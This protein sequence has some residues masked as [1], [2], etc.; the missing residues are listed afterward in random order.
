MITQQ[1][2]IL[3]QE[4]TMLQHHTSIMNKL[5]KIIFRHHIASVCLP[6]SKILHKN[7]VVVALRNKASKCSHDGPS[8]SLPR[9][10]VGQLLGGGTEFLHP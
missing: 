5:G 6:S 4:R 2:P 9:P 1:K 3:V 7:I 8:S 10:F